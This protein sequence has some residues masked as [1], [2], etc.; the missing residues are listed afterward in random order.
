MDSFE[1]ISNWIDFANDNGPPN[2]IKILV[3]NK[4]DQVKTRMVDTRCGKV[5]KNYIDCRC[6]RRLIRLNIKL[7]NCR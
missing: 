2:A 7:Y 1:S 4:C 6:K 5:N 3:G